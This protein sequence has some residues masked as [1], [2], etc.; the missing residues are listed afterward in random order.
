MGRT[1]VRDYH[2]CPPTP[3]PRK[4]HSTNGYEVDFQPLG[5]RGACAPEQSF[6][7]L[8]RDLGVDLISICGGHGHCGRCKVQ[9]VAGATTEL[10]ELEREHLSA[11]EIGDGYR[12][13]CMTQ[14]RSDCTLGVPRES[15]SI[16]MRSQVESLETGILVEPIVQTVEL[17][18][19]PPS[20]EHPLAD[21]EA[22]L[23]GVRE[24]G[25]AVDGLDVEVLRRL[26]PELR[27]WEWRCAAHVRGPEVVDVAAPGS[28]PVGL[29]VDLGTT[30][31]AGYLVDLEEG[32]VLATRGTTNPQIPFGE[33]VVS[34]IVYARQSPES[35]RRLQEVAV[36]GLNR[37]AEELCAEV[38]LTPAA[39]VD[40]VVVGNTA[41]HH[42][43]LGLP[44][45]QLALA[46]FVPAV[47]GELTVK[48][49]DVG[50]E[51]ARGSY[52]YLPP[53]I[54][55]FVGA[56]HVAMLLATA[57]EWRGRNAIALDIGTN[58]E[59]SL[60]TAGGS[61]RSLSCPSGPAFEGYHVKHGTRATVGAIERIQVTA[62]AVRLQTIGGAPPIG[63]CGSGIV[64]ALG[65]LHLAGVLSPNGR[66]Q[67][68]SHFGVREEDG[69][70]EF[71]LAGEDETDGRGA[72]TVTQ[73]DL[74]EILLA[75][76]A[77]QS[78]IEVLL[79][80]SGLAFDDIELIVVAGA[81]GSYIDLENAIAIGMFPPLPLE[82]F[83]QVGNAAGMG[84]KLALISSAVREQAREL[85]GRVDYIELARY[86]KFPRLYA[87]NCLLGEAQGS[88]T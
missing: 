23:A 31:V 60:V 11:H 4:R 52:L 20:L 1:H 61:I 72:I 50:L 37:L 32:R 55:A 66:I 80:S 62:D 33:D 7:G 71:V 51:L 39:V 10:T 88:P 85:C 35:R 27:A 87:R 57:D 86:P 38:G 41:M 63:I 26:S 78:G 36:A 12:L 79:G 58:T 25:L 14:P 8:A 68:G 56:D 82:R 75:K 6:L 22:V 13:A 77:V 34:R 49:R 18:L 74:R 48:A 45:E 5:R 46:P 67:L 53:N 43:L 9:V 64:D 44:T 73:D 70:R 17:A 30:G 15:M 29:A 2:Y 21:G 83:K 65:Q 28:K 54:A 40:A 47:S 59:I 76:A 69:R 42:L 84:A 81:F 24:A 16:P 19:R 3:V